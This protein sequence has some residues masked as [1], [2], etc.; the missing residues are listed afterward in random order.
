MAP[1]LSRKRASPG[2]RI[3][4]AL[5]RASITSAFYA[6]ENVVI[7][8]LLLQKMVDDPSG[9]TLLKDHPLASDYLKTQKILRKIGYPIIF[10]HLFL[11]PWVSS[12]ISSLASDYLP[13]G[14]TTMFAF[15]QM[16]TGLFVRG[17]LYQFPLAQL[18]AIAVEHEIEHRK[19]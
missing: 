6:P 19:L 15:V 12:F 18:Y 8:F 2:K 10:A 5:T 16:V 4:K 11:G 13:I 7:S 3:K 1:R 14:Y 9:R 17:D